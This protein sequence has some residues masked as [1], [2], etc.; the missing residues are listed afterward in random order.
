MGVAER[1][2]RDPRGE[3]EVALAV[4][5]DE[6]GALAALEGKIDTRVGRQQMGCLDAIHR[7]ADNPR[8]RNVPPLRAAR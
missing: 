3:I 4:G 7:Q 1:V 6:P 5:R 2:D 8:K